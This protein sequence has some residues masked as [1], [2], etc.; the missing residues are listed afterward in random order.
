MISSLWIDIVN[1]I[2]I[3]QI[4]KQ[5]LKFSQVWNHINDHPNMA[6]YTLSQ[7]RE[8]LS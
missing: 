8:E 1:V 7:K 5:H 3:R 4:D 2:L 6:N